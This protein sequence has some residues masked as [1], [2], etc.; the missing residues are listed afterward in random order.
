MEK[1]TF[2]ALIAILLVAGS[3]ACAYAAQAT[4]DSINFDVP[5]DFK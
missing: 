1:K 5:D 4:F 3:M 2:L